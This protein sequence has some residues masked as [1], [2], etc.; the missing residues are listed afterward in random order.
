MSI[1]K[2]E[3]S[4]GTGK[5]TKNLPHNS[6]ADLI[7]VRD[8]FIDLGFDWLR[9]KTKW[10]TAFADT[11]KLFQSICKG[12]VRVTGCDGRIDVHGFTHRWLAATNAPGWVDMTRKRGPG[13]EV[14]QVDYNNSFATTWMEDRLSSAGMQYHLM[15]LAPR[16]APMWVRD[17][18][19]RTGGKTRGH[20]THQ[21]GLNVDMRL[22]IKNKL[23]YNHSHALK[24]GKDD[25][26]YEDLF[27]IDAARSQ[28][29]AIRAQMKVKN[30]LFNDETLRKERLCIH[31]ANHGGHYHITI[32]PPDRIDGVYR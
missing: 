13:W 9:G 17:F 30:I 4:V 20:G 19:K 8:R 25:R 2:L 22:P 24:Q 12:N 23:T 14:V 1:L 32:V 21:T 15:S 3:G 31:H 6:P 26:D 10:D 29:K 11:V 18:S 27:D 16:T 5:S 28:L 7:A